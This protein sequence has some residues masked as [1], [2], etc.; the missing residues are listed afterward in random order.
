MT[1]EKI[2]GAPRDGT[3]ILIFD[4]RSELKP[5][6][7]AHWDRETEQWRDDAERWWCPTHW[8]ALPQQPHDALNP[9][10]NGDTSGE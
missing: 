7:L 5:I 4:P 8:H 9:Q 10:R 6:K 2:D 3:R 1:W